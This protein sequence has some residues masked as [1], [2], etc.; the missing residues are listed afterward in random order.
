MFSMKIIKINWLTGVIFLIVL[1]FLIVSL[2][3]FFFWLAVIVFLFSLVMGIV[4][5]I[6]RFLRKKRLV[7]TT[8]SDF[9]VTPLPPLSSIVEDIRENTPMELFLEEIENGIYIDE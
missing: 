8:V 6:A 7:D 5:W 2:S 1:I 9:K 4:G 3:V